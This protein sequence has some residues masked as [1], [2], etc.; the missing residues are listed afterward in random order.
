[1]GQ[2]VTVQSAN[3]SAPRAAK[4]PAPTP[5]QGSATT[6]KQYVQPARLQQAA[7]FYSQVETELDDMRKQ[8]RAFPDQDPSD[9]LMVISGIAGRLAEIRAWLYR[10]NSQ[11]CTQI[12]TREVDPLRDDLDLQFKLHSRRI[13]LMEWELRLS[14][15]GV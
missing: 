3:G 12:R 7:G 6:S 15:G 2:T 8:V 4:G 13:A 10:D 14:G 9:V 1:M 11:R 5:K